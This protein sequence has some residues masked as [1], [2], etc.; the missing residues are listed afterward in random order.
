MWPLTFACEQL[1]NNNNV[2][3]YVSF[4]LESKDKFQTQVE[5]F[6]VKAF[7]LKLRWRTNSC[8]CFSDQSVQEGGNCKPSSVKQSNQVQGHRHSRGVS[9][10]IAGCFL[11]TFV[12][13]VL[14]SSQQQFPSHLVQNSVSQLAGRRS[15]SQQGK[16]GLF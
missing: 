1:C 2:L 11:S 14:K 8:L 5:I 4:F 13:F 6:E 3:K 15:V 16:I 7:V 10:C 9:V 12:S